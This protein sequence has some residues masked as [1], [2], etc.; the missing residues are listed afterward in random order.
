M[1][2]KLALIFMWENSNETKILSAKLAFRLLFQFFSAKFYLLME[3]HLA[4]AK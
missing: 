3:C 1:F 2:D 4:F